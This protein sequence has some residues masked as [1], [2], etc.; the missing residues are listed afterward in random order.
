MENLK[1]LLKLFL[2]I[3]VVGFLTDVWHKFLKV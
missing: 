2:A 1:T 3:E